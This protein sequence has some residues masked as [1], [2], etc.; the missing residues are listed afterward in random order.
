M[1]Q[2]F[3]EGN[4]NCVSFVER[5]CCSTMCSRWRSA[6]CLTVCIAQGR[7]WQYCNMYKIF[8]SFQLHLSTRNFFNIRTLGTLATRERYWLSCSWGEMFL[9][10]QV[11]AE[12]LAGTDQRDDDR[13]SNT[14]QGKQGR[15]FPVRSLI[16]ASSHCCDPKNFRLFF[17]E[18]SHHLFPSCGDNLGCELHNRIVEV[19][20]TTQARDA[21][22]LHCVAAGIA[23]HPAIYSV[24]TGDAFSGG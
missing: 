13:I 7:L 12:R 17:S 9:F 18:L 11:T 15:A 8:R 3:C 22:L 16:V 2:F 14:W 10:R 20:F 19:H 1:R 24:G 5:Y 21:F 23:A 4:L 6:F